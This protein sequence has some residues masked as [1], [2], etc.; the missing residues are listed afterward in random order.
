MS[1]KE[2]DPEGK[3][4][5]LTDEELEKV[6]GGETVDGWMTVS[7][8]SSGGITAAFPDVCDTPTSPNPVPIPYPNVSST[9]DESSATKKTKI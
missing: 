4:D 1:K 5:A 2:K 7:V 3:D 8:K 6:S 9:E